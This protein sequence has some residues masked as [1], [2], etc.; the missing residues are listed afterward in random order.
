MKNE[1]FKT[2]LTLPGG[3]EIK[4][5][6]FNWL[7]Y[8]SRPRISRYYATLCDLLAELFNLKIKEFASKNSIH[9]FQSL[10]Q[11]HKRALEDISMISSALEGKKTVII[12]RLE[13][14][15]GTPRTKND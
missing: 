13:L 11:S 10:L 14:N 8:T 3:V 6:Q 1:N 2:V 7:L 12:S 4:V 9:S 15:D 5:N